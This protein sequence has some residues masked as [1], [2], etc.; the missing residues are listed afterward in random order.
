MTLP[1]PLSPPDCDLRD[2]RWMKLDLVAL[3]NSSFNA[4]VD[5]TA[6]RAGV[7]LWGKAWHQ[8]PAGSLPDGDAE[9]C[10]LAGF[11][12][13][14]KTWKKIRAGALYGFIKCADGRLYHS[15]LCKMANDALAEK[16]V[17]EAKKAA[18]RERK[19][20]GK[21]PNSTI[22]D[23]KT[24]QDIRAAS[25]G[26]PPETPP[27]IPGRSNGIPLENAVEGEEKRRREESKQP[28]AALN[29]G[30]QSHVR[31][32]PKTNR[33]TVNGYF[34]DWTVEKVLEAAGFDPARSTIT[35]GPV[36]EWLRDGYK[37]ETCIAGVKRCVSRPNYELPKS[38]NY[39]LW[40]IKDEDS[41]LPPD[42]LRFMRCEPAKPRLVSG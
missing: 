6:W 26:I 38:L 37:P 33:K 19:K 39:F 30:L 2:F 8:V 31:H 42:P 20:G 35:T 1:E 22:H 9:L 21:A 7:T 25:T 18:D 11:G 34:L 13:D 10:S 28:R 32:D 14:L 5:D 24:P 40:A 17:F 29:V 23:D 4:M 15:Y 27:E 12:R 36:I 41:K 3:F 16:R